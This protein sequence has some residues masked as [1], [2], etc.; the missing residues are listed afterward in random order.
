MLFSVIAEEHKDN[1]ELYFPSDV[2][3]TSD[4]IRTCK[5]LGNNIPDK[6]WVLYLLELFDSGAFYNNPRAI[7]LNLICQF[8]EYN[9]FWAIFVDVNRYKFTKVLPAVGHSYLREI[10]L[11]KYGNSIEYRVMDLNASSGTKAIDCFLFQLNEAESKNMS[12]QGL[13]QFTGITWWNK[14]ENSPFPI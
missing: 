8:N 5:D 1:P 14:K 10:I 4:I 6:S 13:N 3:G 2:V 12:F 11:H 7:E 9:N